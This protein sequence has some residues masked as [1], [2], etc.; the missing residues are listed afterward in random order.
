MK[1]IFIFAAFVFSLNAHC[2]LHYP[3]DYQGT[4]TEHKKE[5]FLFSA[6]DSFH[7]IAKTNLSSSGNLPDRLDWIFPLPSLPLKYEEVSPFLFQEL[8]ELTF[9][10]P[11]GLRGNPLLGES[12]QTNS[13]IKVHEAQTVGRYKIRPLEIL[14]ANPNTANALDT[15]LKS[16]NLKEMPKDKQLRYLK[17]GAVFLVI[18]ANLKGMKAVDFKPLHIVLKPL[19]EYTLPLNFTHTGRTYAVEVYSMNMKLSSQSGGLDFMSS[20][21]FSLIGN[22]APVLRSIIKKPSGEAFKYE[23]RF[24]GT[25]KSSQDPVFKEN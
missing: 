18:E 19:K 1:Q 23:G 22:T 14:D 8:Y 15:W 21:K 7:L 16:N 13:G 24:L 17:K 4:V 20:S 25:V 11:K 12:L 2:C 3:K 6:K 9:S 10:T 5:F